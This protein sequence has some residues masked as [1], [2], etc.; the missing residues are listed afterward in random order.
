MKWEH[1]KSDSE[2]GYHR[3]IVEAAWNEIVAD[4]NDIVARYA[5]VRLPGFRP[6]KAPRMAIEARFRREIMDDLAHRCAERLGREAILETGS[7]AT[8]PVHAETIECEKDTAFRFLVRF[9]PM[10]KIELPEFSKLKPE[11]NG[12]DAK[13]W[14]SH[15]LL[16]LV[17]FR[18]P[19]EV[20]TNELT[21]DGTV[22]GTPESAEWRA[23]EERIRLM[24]ILKRIAR[25]E[26]IEVDESDIDRRTAEKA[27]EFG[28]SKEKLEEELVKGGGLER[29]RDMLLAERTLDYLL[30]KIRVS[31]EE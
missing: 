18:V 9:H 12:T 28:T 23:A 3:L 30:E 22:G 14:I 7:E 1:T 10:P 24:L 13:D 8:G 16:D 27:K 11:D 19:D 4:Y 6:G 31:S 29:L 20:V 26:G 15:R 17:R 25:Q 5:K 2:N 21:F